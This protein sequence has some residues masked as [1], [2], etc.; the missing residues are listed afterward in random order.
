MLKKMLLAGV[1]LGALTIP[2][3]GKDLKVLMIGNS[4]SISVGVFLPKIVN[5]NPEHSLE[6]TN[7]G[8]SV[9]TKPCRMRGCRAIHTGGTSLAVWES[10]LTVNC[11]K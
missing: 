8:Q 4:F 2:A 11:A 9:R 3:A 10:S 7:A 6:L 5:V 1:I